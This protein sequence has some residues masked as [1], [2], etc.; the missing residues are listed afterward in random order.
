MQYFDYQIFKQYKYTENLTGTGS[1]SGDFNTF[2]TPF[3]DR[4]FL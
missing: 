3:F 1:K 2:S 4:L